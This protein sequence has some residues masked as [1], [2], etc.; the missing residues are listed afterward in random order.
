MSDAGETLLAMFESVREASPLVAAELD[1]LF[2]LV[3]AGGE[4]WSGREGG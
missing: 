3:R 4:R 2:G 1:R